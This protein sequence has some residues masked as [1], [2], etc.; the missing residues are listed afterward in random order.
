MLSKICFLGSQL[1]IYGW[2]DD[3]VIRGK[4]KLTQTYRSKSSDADGL[5]AKMVIINITYSRVTYGVNPKPTY[6]YKSP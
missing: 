3:G 6:N 1:C 4:L 5:Q 2:S